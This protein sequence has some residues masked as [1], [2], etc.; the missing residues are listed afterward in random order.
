MEVPE[1][2]AGLSVEECSVR[3]MGKGERLDWQEEAL[4]V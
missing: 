1:G 2:K 3:C 4:E